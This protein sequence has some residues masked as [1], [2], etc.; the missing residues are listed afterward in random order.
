MLRFTVPEELAGER[1][2]QALSALLPGRTRAGLQKLIADGR[3]LAGG[4]KGAQNF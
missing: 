1:L 3:G 4:P 2:D